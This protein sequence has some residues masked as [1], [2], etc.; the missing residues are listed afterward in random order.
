M[1]EQ[2]SCPKCRSAQTRVIGRSLNPPC[3]YIECSHCGYS[4]SVAQ[5]AAP[6]TPP[7]NLDTRRIEQIA[8]R[9][10]VDA[11]SKMTLVGVEKD[12]DDAWAVVVTSDERRV[13]RLQVKQGTA[14]AIRTA[15]IDGL[16]RA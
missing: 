1:N 7:L 15:I 13:V 6:R 10:L 3:L 8:R 16:A 4:T 11:G 14:Y 2:P 5:P 9:A 12:R